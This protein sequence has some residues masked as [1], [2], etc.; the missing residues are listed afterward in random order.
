M[1]V[2]SGGSSRTETN[3]Y[4][5]FLTLCGGRDIWVLNFYLQMKQKLVD[6]SNFPETFR[7]NIYMASSFFPLKRMNFLVKICWIHA[8]II[9]VYTLYN[10]SFK[11]CSWEF[12]YRK[13]LK[14]IFRTHTCGMVT[15]YLMT[16]NA[17]LGD[18]FAQL[19]ECLV[20]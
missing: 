2:W 8:V 7:E 18:V 5:H 1:S 11:C 3:V 15:L 20:N 6:P 19:A 13:Y 9:V 16:L 14:V 12:S 17:F 4:P 10:R